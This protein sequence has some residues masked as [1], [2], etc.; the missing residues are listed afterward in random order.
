MTSPRGLEKVLVECDDRGNGACDSFRSL[1][2][3]DDSS[4]VIRLWLCGRRACLLWFGLD[5]MEKW[6]RSAAWLAALLLACWF[7]GLLVCWLAGSLV[8]V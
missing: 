2:Q 7:A 8:E 5:V 3:E 1:V 4:S 6:K